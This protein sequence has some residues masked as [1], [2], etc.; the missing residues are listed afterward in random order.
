MSQHQQRTPA[1][2]QAYLIK[3]HVLQEIPEPALTNELYDFMDASPSVQ[4]PVLRA[5]AEGDLIYP[6][7]P[8]VAIDHELDGAGYIVNVPL[9]QHEIKSQMAPYRDMAKQVLS[10]EGV[11]VTAQLDAYLVAAGYPDES[12]V[13]DAMAHKMNTR[14]NDAEREKMGVFMRN[15]RQDLAMGAALTNAFTRRAITRMVYDHLAQSHRPPTPVRDL[16]DGDLQLALLKGNL[17]LVRHAQHQIARVS[18]ALNTLLS[19]PVKSPVEEND[20]VRYQFE[21]RVDFP[22]LSVP[23]VMTDDLNRADNLICWAIE[24]RQKS[25]EPVAWKDDVS[26]LLEPF[27]AIASRLA[28]FAPTLDKALTLM[29]REGYPLKGDGREQAAKALVAFSHELSIAAELVGCR[30]KAI[31]SPLPAVEQAYAPV[32]V[33]QKEESPL[34]SASPKIMR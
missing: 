20:S 34:L 25:S 27:P 6:D 28:Q 33:E 8:V 9:L 18:T 30:A 1:D 5:I 23:K 21:Y 10:N 31:E 29:A 14:F 11:S 2:M 16:S 3:N 24:A 4:E 19:L 17:A 22:Q 7:L 15:L 32:A 13:I 12:L 26:A